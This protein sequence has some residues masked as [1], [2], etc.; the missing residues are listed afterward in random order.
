MKKFLSDKARKF[1]GK[2]GLTSAGQLTPAFFEEWA[3]RNMM[4]PV[5]KVSHPDREILIADSHEPIITLGVYRTGY[6]IHRSGL[7]MGNYNDYPME[8]FAIM[9][10]RTGLEKRVAE[11]LA[12]ARQTQKQLKDA[13][14]YDAERKG[15]FNTKL[16]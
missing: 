2:E 16:N 15:R 14:Y 3:K 1:F 13:G 8:D 10:R 7:E 9:T 11:A 4:K 5:C 6:A 12:H